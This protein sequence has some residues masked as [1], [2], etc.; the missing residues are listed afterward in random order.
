MEELFKVLQLGQHT[1]GG[2]FTVLIVIIGLLSYFLISKLIEK[3]K[4]KEFR[5]RMVEMSFNFGNYLKSLEEEKEKKDEQDKDAEYAHGQ[6]LDDIRFLKD[7]VESLKDTILQLNEKDM[8]NGQALKEL[9]K[10]ID[11]V[12]T[13]LID[14]AGNFQVLL[15]DV[16]R[17]YNKLDK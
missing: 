2:L 14:F 4:D 17:I 13:R 11:Q 6:L 3:K 10:N 8:I 1:I 5:K 12:V 15:N 16:N 9:V 7:T